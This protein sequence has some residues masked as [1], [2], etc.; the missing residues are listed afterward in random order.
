VRSGGGVGAARGEVAELRGG[1]RRRLS[2]G[3]G[4]GRESGV[5]SSRQCEETSKLP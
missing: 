2:L 1:D 3:E 4:L 5:L